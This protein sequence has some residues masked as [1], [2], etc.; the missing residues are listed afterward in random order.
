MTPVTERTSIEEVGRWYLMVWDWRTAELEAGRGTGYDLH[1]E[2]R[3]NRSVVRL[4]F[5]W[6]TIRDEEDLAV[7]IKKLRKERGK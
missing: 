1:P 5:P 7:V 6:L 4:K 2:Y 3:V